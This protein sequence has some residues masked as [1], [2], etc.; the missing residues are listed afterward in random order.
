MSPAKFLRKALVTRTSPIACACDLGITRWMHRAKNSS[1]FS[2]SFAALFDTSPSITY[3]SG[4]LSGLCRPVFGHAASEST[5]GPSSPADVFGI[6]MNGSPFI[7][8]GMLIESFDVDHTPPRQF[9]SWHGFAALRVSGSTVA[10][11]GFDI[12]RAP[13][14]RTACATRR[15]SIVRDGAGVGELERLRHSASNHDVDGR[16]VAERFPLH[17]APSLLGSCCLRTPSLRTSCG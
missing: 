6:L 3:R 14:G 13:N 4:F 7:G 9:S 11:E 12:A 2:I 1:C 8:S 10:Q 5:N 17:V 16:H 15:A